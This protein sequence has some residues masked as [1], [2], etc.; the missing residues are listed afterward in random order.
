[1]VR[2][3][4]WGNNEGSKQFLAL[5]ALRDICKPKIEGGLEFHCFK[6]INFALLAKLGWN[7]VGGNASLWCQILHVI[8]KRILL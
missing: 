5:K 1:M 2:R 3:F 8:L 7:V 4:W 6:D